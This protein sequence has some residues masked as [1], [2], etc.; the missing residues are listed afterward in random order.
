V[1]VGERVLMSAAQIRAAGAAGEMRGKMM[2]FAPRGSSSGEWRVR[3]VVEREREC[4]KDARK[5]RRK[6]ASSEAPPPP[7]LFQRSE[8]SPRDIPA[9]D[10]VVDILM[11]AMLL[12]C[13]C[14][15]A[16]LRAR[17]SARRRGCR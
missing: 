14:L 8:F 12:I 17:E 10:V 13:C 3:R 16:L 1:A 2:F 11:P 9:E 5:S 6:D 15:R 7:R 4:F